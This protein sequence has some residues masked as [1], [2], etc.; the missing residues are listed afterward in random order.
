MGSLSDKNETIHV[1]WSAQC[2]HT[3][4]PQEIAITIYQISIT[5]AWVLL[6]CKDVHSFNLQENFIT[7]EYFVNR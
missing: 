6:V 3:V 2:G 5:Y 4:N 1:K 7:T